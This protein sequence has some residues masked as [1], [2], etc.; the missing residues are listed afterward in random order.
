MNT[1]APPGEPLPARRDLTTLRRVFATGQPLVSDLF[2][3]LVRREPVVALEV[4][5]RG[6]DGKVAYS[7]TLNPTT[8]AFVELVR[9][10]GLPE[11]WT[12]ALFDSRG[13]LIARSRDPER[14]VGQPAGPMLLRRLLSEREGALETTSRDG[15]PVLVAFS[16]VGS[17]G[18]AAAVNIP[19]AELAAP[20]WRSAM[21]TLV[22]GLLSLVAGL[23]LALVV[24][25]RITGPI[26]SLRDLAAAP[27]RDRPSAAA[28]TGLAEVDKVA[29]AL[30]SGARER[31][32]AE[33]ALGESG[34]RLRL[35]LDASQL[36]TWLLEVGGNGELIWDARCKALFGLPSDARVGYATWAASIPPEDRPMA[37]AG[38]ARALDPAD[39]HD[40]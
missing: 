34:F 27:D 24:A 39:P 3:G 29:E 32:A 30:V 9:R 35:A 21:R 4:P 20:A 38:V 8:D 23:G 37:E 17:S 13:A 40:E 19:L 26:A 7:L 14:L 28:G 36:G 5:V 33:A 25:R 11:A 12:G 22:S 15:V 31:R 1:A 10:Q 16:R 18:W 2:F 6:P